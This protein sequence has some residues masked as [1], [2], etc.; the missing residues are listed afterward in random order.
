MGFAE[1]KVMLQLMNF[2]QI[3]IQFLRQWSNPTLEQMNFSKFCICFYV[4][5]E[6]EFLYS[7]LLRI[8]HSL[9]NS[10]SAWLE[11]KICYTYL[12]LCFG[13]QAKATL[14][15]T[16]QPWLT[17]C[18]TKFSSAWLRWKNHSFLLEGHHVL[19]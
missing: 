4:Q 19:S 2:L 13:Q 16:I 18:L 17:P 5:L 12:S 6:N 14:Y 3:R 9:K 7:R 11:R 1:S 15:I 10:E 8:S